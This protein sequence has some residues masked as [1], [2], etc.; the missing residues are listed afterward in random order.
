MSRSL[1]LTCSPV[2]IVALLASGCAE[3]P[4][5]PSHLTMH[6]STNATEATATSSVGLL[7][8]VHAASARYHSTTQATKAGYVVAS[9]CVSHPALGAMEVQ[10]RAGRP[11]LR[12]TTAG[13][14]AV[15]ANS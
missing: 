13:G 9:P 5:A 2:M 4:N 10:R 6:G 1:F 14:C 12:A 8:A 15:R 11:R 3:A 7:K